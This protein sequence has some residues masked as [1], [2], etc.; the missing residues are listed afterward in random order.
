MF[1][2]LLVVDPE[3]DEASLVERLSWLERLKSTAAAAQ[4]RVTAALDE[5]RRAAEAATGVPARKRGRGLAS[6]IALARR[7]SAARGGRH[8]GWR[9]RWCTRCRT[10]WQHSKSARF[11]NGVP[12]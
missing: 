4:A 11:R 3:A 10:H 7:D 5:T 12:P 8:L 1:E 6:E 9:R 2:D